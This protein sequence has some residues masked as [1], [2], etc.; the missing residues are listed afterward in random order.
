METLHTWRVDVQLFVLDED[1]T[2]AHAVLT[3]HQGNTIHGH[4]HAKRNP[5]DSGVPEIGEEVAAS[6]ALRDLADHLLQVA[7]EDI[8]DIEH[9]GVH[10]TR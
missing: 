3:T 6:R 8:A 1:R 10:L 2:S 7:S 4:G 9:T 5:V